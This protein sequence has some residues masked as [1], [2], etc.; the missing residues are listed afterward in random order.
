MRK[1]LMVISLLVLVGCS[2]AAPVAEPEATARKLMRDARKENA[3]II[4]SVQ[5][6]KNIRH[7]DEL[8]CIQTDTNVEGGNIPLLF[9][10]WRKGDQWQGEQLT[11]G[12]YDWQVQGCPR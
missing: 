5:G 4:R 1:L 7:V 9:L 6:D 2:A 11:E 10:V 8:W 12:F 3:R